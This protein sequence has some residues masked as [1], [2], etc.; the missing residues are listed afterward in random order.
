MSKVKKLTLLN[1]IS[2]GLERNQKLKALLHEQIK[3]NKHPC[4]CY[5]YSDIP[6][7]CAKVDRA[8]LIKLLEILLDDN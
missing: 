1:L 7:A 3:E 8:D 2:T 6:C 4:N 5:E